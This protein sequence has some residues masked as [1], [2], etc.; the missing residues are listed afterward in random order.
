MAAILRPTTTPMTE[1]DM[2]RELAICKTK[3]DRS[4]RDFSRTHAK[5]EYFELAYW[6]GRKHAMENALEGRLL[7]ETD[8]V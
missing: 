3:Y 4:M 1:A 5:Y 6:L 2:R 7:K 8:D